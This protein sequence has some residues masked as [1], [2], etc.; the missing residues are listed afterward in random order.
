MSTKHN[1]E[2]NVK[3]DSGEFNAEQKHLIRNAMIG[4]TL[5]AISGVAAG[6]YIGNHLGDSALMS[7]APY[8]ARYALDTAVSLG[9][10]V[11]GFV[12]GSFAASVVYLSRHAESSSDRR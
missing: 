11:A 12:S 7:S 4:G 1:L 5:G 2:G 10:G 9:L 6:V 3:D 8:M